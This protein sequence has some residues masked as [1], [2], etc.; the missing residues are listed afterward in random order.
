MTSLTGGHPETNFH[1]ESVIIT[2]KSRLLSCIY[3]YTHLFLWD[4]LIVKRTKPSKW[5][6][7]RIHL[8]MVT[9]LCKY[10]L[11]NPRNLHALFLTRECFV[12]IIYDIIMSPCV[13]THRLLHIHSNPCVVLRV[14]HFVLKFFFGLMFQL[15]SILQLQHGSQNLIHFF[16]SENSF[17]RIAFH[18][19]SRI[20]TH[21]MKQEVK[22]V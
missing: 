8:H 6:V 10:I 22:D 16:C 21:E 19:L 3:T 2:S 5:A 4:S 14:D 12:I 11:R 7:R 13:H 18:H 20:R 9:I 17:Q 15:F 1:A